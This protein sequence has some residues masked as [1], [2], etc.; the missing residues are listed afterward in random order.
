MMPLGV[1]GILDIIPENQLCFRILRHW[2]YLHIEININLFQDTKDSP[3]RPASIITM[4]TST[5]LMLG[6]HLELI[7]L[8]LAN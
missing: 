6:L 7:T 1:N 3:T 8:T 2:D 5:A 4:V